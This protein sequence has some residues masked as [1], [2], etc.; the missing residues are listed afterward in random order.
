MARS[1]AIAAL[2]TALVAG[3]PALA[4]EQTVQLAV[5]NMTCAGCTYIVKRT[6]ASVPGVTRV[7][8]SYRERAAVVT[9]DDAATEVAALTEATARVGY[10]SQVVK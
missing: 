8:V 2:A 6:L 10:P 1:I 4:A 7:A 3:G 5:D 9:F